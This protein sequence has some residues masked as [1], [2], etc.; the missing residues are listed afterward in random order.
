VMPDRK[1]KEEISDR[2]RR[3]FD[4]RTRGASN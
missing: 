3:Y 1:I 4:Y 2:T